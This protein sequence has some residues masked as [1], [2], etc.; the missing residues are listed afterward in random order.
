MR[1]T[2]RQKCVNQEN[3]MSAG[4]DWVNNC[5]AGDHYWAATTA[6]IEPATFRSQVGDL[7]AT[8]AAALTGR[9]LKSAAPGADAQR[10]DDIVYR[11]AGWQ[12][13][14]QRKSFSS[15]RRWIYN[16]QSIV[17]SWHILSTRSQPAARPLDSN[18]IS[19]ESPLPTQRTRSADCKNVRPPPLPPTCNCLDG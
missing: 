5:T 7:T 9:W 1:R 13:G 10:T 6:E 18:V 16:S 4:R 8:T 11:P 15:R 3:K 19:V 17:V 2:T 12:A 14:T